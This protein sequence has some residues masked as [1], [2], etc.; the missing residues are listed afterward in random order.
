VLS[1]K[2]I[3]EVLK[4]LSELLMYDYVFNSILLDNLIL[5]IQWEIIFSISIL[6]IDE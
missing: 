6:L 3:I 1:H 2:H 4:P 5:D